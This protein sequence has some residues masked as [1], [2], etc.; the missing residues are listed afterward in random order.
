MRYH[1]LYAAISISLPFVSRDV[2]ASNLQAAD[3]LPR[4][5][6]VPGRNESLSATSFSLE[7]ADLACHAAE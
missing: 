4:Q 3:T 6:Q 7:E 2:A 5:L 1:N